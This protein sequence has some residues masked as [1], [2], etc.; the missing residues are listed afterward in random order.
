MVADLPLS[1][2]TIAKRLHAAGYLT[3]LVGKWHL[4]DAEHYPEAHGFDVNIGGT[5]WGAPAPTFIP[6]AERIR[7]RFATCR[8]W[9]MA[10]TANISPTA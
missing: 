9:S 6:I 2:I 10:S 3:A 8:T 1:E 7:A 4:G 5:G